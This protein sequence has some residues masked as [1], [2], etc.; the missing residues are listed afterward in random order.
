MTLN[1]DDHFLEAP[2]G[3]IP[4]V[5]RHLAVEVV[6]RAVLGGLRGVLNTILGLIGGIG[7]HLVLEAVDASL[8][9]SLSIDTGASTLLLVAGSELGR[10][11]GIPRSAGMSGLGRIASHILHVLAGE[12]RVLIDEIGSL[13]FQVARRKIRCLM[14]GVILGRTIDLRK[15]ILRG[16]DL[17]GSRLRSI[18]SHVAKENGRIAH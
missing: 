13:A 8:G 16:I 10:I 14:P 3:L 17:I 15:L 1:L 4:P 12:R 18:A 5:F 11:L 2:D 6:A 9:T 7:R